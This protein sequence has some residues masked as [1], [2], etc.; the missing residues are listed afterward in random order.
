MMFPKP[1]KA[2]RVAAKKVKRQSRSE[3]VSELR[4]RAIA[5][6]LGRCEAPDCRRAGVALSMD[7]WL[8]GMGRRRVR[9][10]IETVWML[11]SDCDFQR[12]R[13]MPNAKRWN[14]LFAMHCER[15]GYPPPVR[16]MERG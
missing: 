13:N 3:F 14:D 8:G 15:H 12:T 5:R 1:T 7:H 16:H 10:S 4:D 9:E 2:A 11:C 6:S